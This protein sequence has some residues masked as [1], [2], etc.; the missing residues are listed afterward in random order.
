VW[1]LVHRTN[2]ALAVKD[3]IKWSP[4]LFLIFI[5]LWLR[6][7]NLGY[8]D[9][10]GDEIKAMWRPEPD[11]SALEFLYTQK[12]GPIEFL[13]SY[14]VKLIN[15]SYSNEFLLRLP[16]ALAGIL[17][18]YFFYKLVRLHFGSK[19]A[20][21]ATLLLSINGIFVGLMRIAQYQGF[22]IL[23]S[24]LT[25][26]SFSLAVHEPKWRI[27]GIYVGVFFWT[28]TLLTHY[29][30][31]FIAP[32]AIYLL[33]RWY[34]GN[35]ELPVG[36]RLKHLAIPFAISALALAAYFVPLLLSLSSNTK[37]YWTGRITGK[38]V[39]EK[40]AIS[41]L[42]NFELYNPIFTIYIYIAF[43]LL[44]LPKIKTTY[45]LILWFALPWTVLELVIFDPGT[46]IYTYL[47]PASILVAF[48]L[49]VLEEIVLK[50]LG[51]NW[52]MRLN[53][54]GL[55]LLFVW[56]AGVSHLIFVDHTPEY[57]YEERKILFWVIGGPGPVHDYRPWT[58][59]FPYYRGWEEIGDFVTTNENN[60]YY[61]T[62]EDTSISIYYIPFTY[63]ADRAGYYIYIHAPQSFE[64]KDRDPKPQ[65]WRKHYKPVKV[66]EYNGKAV[67][68]IYYMP[69]G[70]LEEIREAGY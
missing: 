9:F 61:T 23:F 13:V 62:N 39:I 57:P 32:F 10:Y 31:I 52:G 21:Y 45:P 20:L 24:I 30:G 27:R 2:E 70:S 67:A 53:I 42:L 63:F 54:T 48:G 16:F 34:R 11:Q 1:N 44:S 3:K 5:T 15:P 17:A 64:S 41:S 18:I 37:D 47:I 22:V 19:I 28:A 65:Y 69:P 6:L 68:E 33:V 59:G 8:S 12:K 26:Y 66:V 56:L 46:H 60:G 50:I 43:A 51:S 4:I 38:D 58:Y 35:A 40:R 55:A 36:V 7:A 49:E 14:L 29:D 25:L